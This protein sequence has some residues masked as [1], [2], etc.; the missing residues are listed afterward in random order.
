MS[1]RDRTLSEPDPLDAPGATGATVRGGAARAAAWSAGAV[2]SLV[3][4]PLLVRHLG[5]TRFGEYVTVLS[6]INIAALA[7]D[8]G[9]GALALREWAAREPRDRAQV[10]A[11][12]LGLR[13][14]VASLGALTA[15]VFAVAAD[16]PSAMV[17]GTAIAAL[18]VFAQVFGDFALVA[19]AGSLRFGAVAAVELARS[20]LGTAG[21]VVLVLAGS[22]L[23]PFFAAYAVAALI[24]AVLAVALARGQVSL[25]P[26][27]GT[28]HWRPL[29]ADAAA[30]AAAA[31]V[32]V[33]YLRVVMVVVSLEA[34]GR[35]SGLFATAFHI[36]EFAAAVA[37]VLAAT[38][39]PLL[40]RAARDDRERLGRGAGAALRA[41]LLVGA[42]GALALGLGAPTVVDLIGGGTADAAPVLRIEAAAIATA[43]ASFALGAV[44]LV[45]RR[46]RALLVVNVSGLVVALGAALV[47]VPDHGARGA[48]VAAVIGEAVIAIGQLTA[49]ARDLPIGSQLARALAAIVPAAAAAVGVFALL[50]LPNALAT[51]AALATFVGVVALLRGVPP[52]LRL[53]AFPARNV[54]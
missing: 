20:A 53:L 26:R 3:S 50:P 47:L 39:M 48:A 4:I 22:G 30:Y 17:A 45:L 5:L 7:S 34:S 15:L 2:L 51:V 29:L 9:I 54:G 35:Q 41:G 28:G 43:F 46:Y 25:V 23:V 12:L 36:F 33:V 44:L 19:L 42:F 14:A 52:E 32:H 38:L 10:L 8:L 24:A 31:V 11:S 40:A 16:Y 6:L 13:I 27:F 49:V 18:G 21:I 37:A 1:A